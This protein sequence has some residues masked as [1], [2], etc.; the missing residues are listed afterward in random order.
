[1]G[2]P[3]NAAQCFHAPCSS[4]VPTSLLHVPRI[5][6]TSNPPPLTLPLRNRPTPLIL[7]QPHIPIN[8]GTKRRKPHT[9]NSH[10]LGPRVPR[11]DTT[12]NAAA[13]NAIVEIVLSAE[14]L[15]GALGAAEDCADFGEVAARGERGAVHVV[16]AVAEL[17]AEGEVGGGGEG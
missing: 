2:I 14:A 3:L 15:D 9:P 5:S 11:Q 12:R 7:G 16:Q 1:M 17:S 8:R 4:T 13:G 6:Y 10:R